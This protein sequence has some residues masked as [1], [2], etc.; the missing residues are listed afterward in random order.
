MKHAPLA[1]CDPKS[2]VEGDL[3]ATDLPSESY[4]GEI[5]YLK[6][7]AS[8]RFYWMSNQAPDQLTIFMTWDS[9]ASKKE[10]SR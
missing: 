7:N 10:E 5:Y 6:Y 1:I 8:Q 2:L 3:L 9:G 4:V